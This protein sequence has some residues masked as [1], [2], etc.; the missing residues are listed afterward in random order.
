MSENMILDI[1]FVIIENIKQP[2]N[3][4]ELLQR[5]LLI[6]IWIK[7]NKNIIL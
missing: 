6:I 2:I 1:H 4:K 5:I 7:K 3:I